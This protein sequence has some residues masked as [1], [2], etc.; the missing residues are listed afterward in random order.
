MH[1]SSV[2]TKTFALAMCVWITNG[3]AATTEISGIKGVIMV[4]PSRPGPIK[5]ESESPTAAPLSNA[6]FIVKSDNKVVTTFSTNGDGQFEVALKPGHY[7][8]SSSE[9]RFPKP[10]GPFE[11]NVEPGKM[12]R[13]EWRC[14]SGMR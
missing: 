4:S 9:S 11:V 3:H 5:K 13:V 10:C 7:T 14:D 8:V 1:G 12:L 2:I 6:K